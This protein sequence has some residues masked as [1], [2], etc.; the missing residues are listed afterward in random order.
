MS[1]MNGT[2]GV[3][4]CVDVRKH[5]DMENTQQNTIKQIWHVI[6]FFLLHYACLALLIR[7]IRK[8]ASEQMDQ[9]DQSLIT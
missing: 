5:K 7:F 2:L 3:Y 1:G 8:T 6:L 4:L 9:M